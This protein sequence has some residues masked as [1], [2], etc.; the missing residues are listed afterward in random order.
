MKRQEF[1]VNEV[2]LTDGSKIYDAVGFDGN[3]RVT[4][5]CI[6]QRNAELLCGMLNGCANGFVVELAYSGLQE[7]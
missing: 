1:I 3:S 4:F 2:T 5:N 7:G 6:D